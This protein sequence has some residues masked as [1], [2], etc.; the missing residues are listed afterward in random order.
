MFKTQMEDNKDNMFL[1]ANPLIFQR[2][3]DLRRK[4]TKTEKELWEVLKNKK[5]GGFKFRRQHPISKFILDFYCH[6]AKFGIEIDGKVHNSK[7][8]KFYDD[9]RSEILREYGIKIIR[10]Q[11]DE[12]I[13]NIEEVKLKILSELK[14]ER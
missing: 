8:Q 5:L 4:M 12:I 11:N 13:E 10:F 7:S 6:E 3:E 9:D 2:A 1:G 14:R